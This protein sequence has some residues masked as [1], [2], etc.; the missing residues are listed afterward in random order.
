T[1]EKSIEAKLSFEKTAPHEC[2]KHICS[3][4]IVRGEDINE[5]SVDMPET[6]R[7]TF[8]K[9]ALGVVDFSRI[10]VKA[11]DAYKFTE[12]QINDLDQRYVVARSR[13]AVLKAELSKAQSEVV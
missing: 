7:Y 4:T 3:T 9:A 5:L 12:N 11:K 2:L 13:V 8:V 1:D 10:E 6:E